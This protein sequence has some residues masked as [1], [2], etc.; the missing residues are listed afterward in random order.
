[1]ARKI[2]RICPVCR[3]QKHGTS[4]HRQRF[5][6]PEGHPLTCG[7]DV[8][9]CTQCGFVYAD[10]SATQGDYDFFY[11]KHS[12]YQNHS[13]SGGGETPWDEERFT[14]TAQYVAR[15]ISD[16]NSLILDIGCANGGLL[17]AF[18]KLGYKNLHGV[19]PSPVCVENTKKC[20]FM[21]KSGNLTAMPSE[22]KGFD[23]VCLSHV[24]EHVL[25]MDTSINAIRTVLKPGGLCYVETPDALRYVLFLKSPFQDFNTEHINH[26]SVRFLSQLFKTR[27]GWRVIDLGTKDILSSPKNPFPSCYGL[28]RSDDQE[29]ILQ[30]PALTADLKIAVKAYV[31]ASGK[32]LDKIET[33]LKSIPVLST[34]ILV[35]GT[36]QLCM[37]LLVDTSLSKA[38]IVSFVDGN[39]VNWGQRLKGVPITDPRKIKDTNLPILIASLLNQAQIE[40][41][42]RVKWGLT[43]PIIPLLPTHHTQGI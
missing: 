19:D 31:A 15:F 10:I 13:S 34:G 35:W 43:N 36:G 23:V 16:K 39:S 25:D 33:N 3:G 37:K 32:L 26:F 27:S 4:L 18:Q 30:S 17:K 21:A 8:V 2:S 6:L 29:P 28:L 22:L 1:M 12:I 38:N 9:C 40:N 7:Y 14:E 42:I 20:G 24:L 11:K 41:D 5:L